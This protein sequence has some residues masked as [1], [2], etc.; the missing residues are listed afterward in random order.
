[1]KNLFLVIAITAF[2]SLNACCQV[3]KEVPSN[4][5]SA[6]AK[7]F[8]KATNVKWAKENSK[9][10]EAE[11]KMNAKEYSANFDF[12]GK[13]VE[14]EHEIS[15]TEIPLAIKAILDKEF[16]GYKIKESEISETEKAKL[17]EFELQKDGKKTEVAIDVNGKIIK[18]EE[19]KKGKDKDND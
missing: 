8:P 9:E 17:Y 4:I 18:K 12:N 19:A 1:M 13:C 2:V 11:F 10:W 7:Q 14:T 5:K 15:V 3:G 6:F 16:A